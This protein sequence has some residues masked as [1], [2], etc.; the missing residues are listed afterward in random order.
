MLHKDIKSTRRVVALVGVAVL[1]GFIGVALSAQMGPRRGQDVPPPPGAPG[2]GAGVGMGQPGPGMPGMGP[3]RRGRGMRGGPGG[4]PI[5]L[6][7]IGMRELELTDAQREQIRGVAESHR[8]QFKGTAEALMKARKEL[9]DVITSGSGDEA[10]IRE[11]AAAVAKV[12]AD[13]AVSQAKLHNEVFQILTPEQQQ[14]ARELRSLRDKRMLEGRERLRQRMEQRQERKLEQQSST[15]PG[16]LE[17][18]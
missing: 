18:V 12:E 4:G 1:T 3:G 11:K 13:A 14:K 15:E 8:E 9:H 6:M 10:A 17:A 7:G 16:R 2:M 5:G